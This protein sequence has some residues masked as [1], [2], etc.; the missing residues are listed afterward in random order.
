MVLKFKMN[1][2]RVLDR[3]KKVTYFSV[4]S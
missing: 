4:Q 1:G 3:Y 2:V